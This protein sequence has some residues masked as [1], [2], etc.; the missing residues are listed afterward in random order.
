MEELIKLGAEDIT[1]HL[2]Q[3]SLLVRVEFTINGATATLNYEPM[4]FNPK[5]D[6]LPLYGFNLKGDVKSLI[7]LIN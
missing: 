2:N 7:A 4:V 3:D 1:L 6:E 5:L